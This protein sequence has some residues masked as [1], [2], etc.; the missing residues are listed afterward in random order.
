MILLLKKYIP[1][2]VILIFIFSCEDNGGI[3]NENT[4]I[5]GCTDECSPSF[6]SDATLDDGTC[7]YTYSYSIIASAIESHGCLGCHTGL[8][9]GNLDLTSYQ[10]LMSSNTNSGGIINDCDDYSS[11]IILSKLD[12]GSMSDYASETLIDM[13]TIWIQEGAIE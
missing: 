10:G 7:E 8:S 5:Y 6:D 3:L 1:Y 12:G 9:S 11:S 13:L 2:F 4:S